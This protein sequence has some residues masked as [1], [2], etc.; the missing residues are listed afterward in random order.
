MNKPEINQ[1]T[2]NSY[3]ELLNK[4]KSYANSGEN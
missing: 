3:E 1:I 2:A 4:V